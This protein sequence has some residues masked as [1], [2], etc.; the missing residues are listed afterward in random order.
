MSV[1]EHFVVAVCGYVLAAVLQAAGMRLY[2]TGSRGRRRFGVALRISAGLVSTVTTTSWLL[3]AALSG[4]LAGG[5]FM[6]VFLFVFLPFVV[7]F[8]GL[9]LG[10]LRERRGKTEPVWHVVLIGAFALACLLPGTV[11]TADGLMH[12]TGLAQPVELKVTEVIDRDARPGDRRGFTDTIDGDYVLDGKVEHLEDSA[13][14]SLTP[15]PKEGD[16]IRV[17][18]SRLW[19]TVMIETTSAAWVIVGFGAFGLAAG[20]ALMAFALRERKRSEE[21]V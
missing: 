2:R 9:R 12:L 6:F 5:V 7:C 14:M 16:T 20:G 3:P 18:L 19:P 11:A 17:T 8:V 15:L 21:P 13:W 1:L 10:K 4:G